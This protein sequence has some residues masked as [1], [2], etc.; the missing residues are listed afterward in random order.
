MYFLKLIIEL[1]IISANSVI[2]NQINSKINN[3]LLAIKKIL[4]IHNNIK[5]IFFGF[6]IIF[7]FKF[8]LFMTTMTKNELN[9]NINY[10]TI[11]LDTTETSMAL[12][13]WPPNIIKAI[14]LAIVSF[15]SILLKVYI[16]ILF[17]L[18]RKILTESFSISAAFEEFTAPLKDLTYKS[19]IFNLLEDD[20]LAATIF[21]IIIFII[22]VFTIRID[23]NFHQFINVI[24]AAFYNCI[25]II[26]I[27]MFFLV[28]AIII[29]NSKIPLSEELKN[30]IFTIAEKFIKPL[31]DIFS[32][33]IAKL[34][35]LPIITFIIILSVYLIFSNILLQI[36]NSYNINIV[37]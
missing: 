35:L 3:I 15:L 9:R 37:K 22:V 31:R 1:K 28:S 19:K 34:D 24:L 12:N 16:F 18:N 21:L 7:L 33:R 14:Q 17:M 25:D 11:M 13:I 32:I 10:L 29:E 20:N 23:Y 5:I 4:K 27:I 26:E 6:F 2:I 36:F 30:F 8:F